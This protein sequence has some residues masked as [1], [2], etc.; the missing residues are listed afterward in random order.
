MKNEG[1]ITTTSSRILPL[2]PDRLWDDDDDD[3]ERQSEIANLIN[4]KK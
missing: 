2:R 1:K 3:L 4:K